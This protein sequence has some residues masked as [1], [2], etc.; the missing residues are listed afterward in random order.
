[1][2][3]N[4][5]DIK[6]IPNKHRSSASM[7][8]QGHT[9]LRNPAQHS[10]TMQGQVNFKQRSIKYIKW[11]QMSVQAQWNVISPPHPTPPHPRWQ[12]PLLLFE[13]NDRA[14]MQSANSKHIYYKNYKPRNMD[15][16]WKYF[17]ATSLQ[18][19]LWVADTCLKDIP[20]EQIKALPASP[21]FRVP[22]HPLKS[23]DLSWFILSSLWDLRSGMHSRSSNT[24][25]R[26]LDIWVCFFSKICQLS[27][28]SLVPE[29]S[30]A[31]WAQFLCDALSGGWS[32]P[33]R[34]P[35]ALRFVSG[36]CSWI[37]KSAAFEK[38]NT[39]LQIWHFAILSMRHFSGLVLSAFYV[40]VFPSFFV[41]RL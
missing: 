15:Y 27:W 31:V 8:K 39:E 4:G 30:A 18:P 23:I 1:M 6:T 36:N 11:D 34:V 17:Q 28:F 14:D 3:N 26:H 13:C 32:Q 10:L 22:W 40:C 37:W 20:T 9:D 35:P 33:C 38:L 21:S 5:F 7:Q 41:K 19:P 2:G 16:F 24:A 29:E 12:A 25:L